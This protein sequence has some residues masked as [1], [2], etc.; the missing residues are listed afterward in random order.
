MKRLLLLTI[1]LLGAL[2]AL[3]ACNN[4]ETETPQVSLITRT[5]DPAYPPAETQTPVEEAAAT[6]TL[7]PTQTEIPP[8]ATPTETAIP[9][10]PTPTSE[11]YVYGMQLGSPQRTLNFAHPDL[12]CNWMG[13]AGQVFDEE[14][15]P[16]NNLVIGIGG[17]IAGNPITGIAITGETDPYGPGGYEIQFGEQPLASVGTAWARVHDL[18]GN[19][20]SAPAYFNTSPSCDENLIVLNF[21]PLSTLP[22]ESVYLPMI[23]K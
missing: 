22:N 13:L 21:V 8:S 15:A 9:A 14:G 12:G 6:V 7:Q 23:K 2:P 20:L 18:D 4:G 19:L 11:P 5:P 1:V 17:S 10:T 3:T 16:V